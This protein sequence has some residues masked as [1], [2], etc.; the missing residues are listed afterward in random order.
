VNRPTST[1]VLSVWP[2]ILRLDGNRKL[3]MSFL[4]PKL[5]TKQEV[6]NVIKSTRDLVLVLRFGREDDTACLQLDD[7]VRLKLNFVEI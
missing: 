7:I 4:L 2:G 5:T 1:F 3:K 6:D